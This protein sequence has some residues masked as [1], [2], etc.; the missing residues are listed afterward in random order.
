MTRRN[1]SNRLLSASLK[2][3]AVASL[4]LAPAISQ[5]ER[6]RPVGVVLESV[7]AQL[8]KAGLSSAIEAKAGQILFPGDVLE[9]TDKAVTLQY[10]PGESIYRL[11]PRSELSVGVQKLKV[12]DVLYRERTCTEPARCPS[13]RNRQTERRFAQILCVDVR[14]A[15]ATFLP[16][17]DGHARARLRPGIDMPERPRRASAHYNVGLSDCGLDD[18][19]VVMNRERGRY[20]SELSLSM[21][22]FA[23]GNPATHYER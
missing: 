2:I 13:M 11:S 7:Q 21:I 23:S 15:T 1:A 8:R 22:R 14:S 20:R 12:L 9:S 6:A 4:G 19:K 16:R 5:N 3:V 18:G 17:R 10:C